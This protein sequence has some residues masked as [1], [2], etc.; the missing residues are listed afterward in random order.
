MFQLFA[1]VLRNADKSTVR[2]F[3]PFS[4]RHFWKGAKFAGSVGLP[5]TKM[6]SA[7]PQTPVIGSCSA[8]AMMPPQP[9]TP[10]TA[11]ACISAV[12]GPS[13]SR[14]TPKDCRTAPQPS[15]K[16]A[17]SKTLVKF[18]HAVFHLCEWTDGQ[19][20]ILI[21]KVYCKSHNEDAITVYETL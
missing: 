9:L 17:L 1:L 11:Y 7:L 10:S 5:M 21:T 14:R 4:A 12:A 15:I 2:P 19:A 6:L 16:K 8:F 3:I 20:N 13:E 18:C